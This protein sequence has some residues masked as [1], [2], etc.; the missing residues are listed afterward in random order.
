MKRI[1]TFCLTLLL[2]SGAGLLSAAQPQLDKTQNLTLQQYQAQ[3]NAD[4]GM[5]KIGLN[6]SDNDVAA[7]LGGMFPRAAVPAQTKEELQAMQLK[8][9]PAAFL[10]ASA[11][12]LAKYENLPKVRMACVDIA[13]MVR[14]LAE[15]PADQVLLLI[16]NEK[17]RRHDER[18]QMLLKQLR[19][20][21]LKA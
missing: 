3:A 1:L 6:L 9:S 8:A 12:V 21:M 19:S 13:R 15:S 18:T 11:E 17:Q 10:G 20:K 7:L 2:L 5:L 4:L 16:K 14:H